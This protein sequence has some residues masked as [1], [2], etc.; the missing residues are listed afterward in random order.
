MKWPGKPS[1]GPP[2]A[3]YERKARSE[4]AR[5]EMS[6]PFTIDRVEGPDA[7]GRVLTGVNG[8]LLPEFQDPP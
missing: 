1:L 4:A 6:R 5:E 8:W 3:S 2:T 7:G